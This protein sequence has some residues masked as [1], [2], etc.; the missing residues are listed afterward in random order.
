MGKDYTKQ[1]IVP[2]CYLA[3]FG[4]NGNEGRRSKVYYY[5]KDRC[6][7]GCGS[8]EKFPVENG[9]YDIPE[10]G[11]KE[12][13]LEFF[14][15]KIETQLSDLLKNLLNFVV[16]EKVDRSGD[17]VYYE[18]S[19]RAELCG[20]FALLIQRTDMQRKQI[21]SIYEQLC[22]GFPFIPVPAYDKEDF[23]RLH[24]NQILDLNQANFY[25]NMFENTK[26]AVLVNHT[27]LPFWTSDN[28]IISINHGTQ[29]HI[30]ATSDH[31]TYYIPISPKFSIEMYPKSVNWNDLAYFDLYD[32]RIIANYNKYI[33]KECTRMV[34]SNKEF[35]F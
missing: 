25:A 18:P 6:V 22:E 24:N 19:M 7:S 14:F 33:E 10:L 31:L 20:Q 12:K 13:A 4:K 21:Q 23:K 9:F 15:Q 30:S 28:P 34:F 32:E 29:E 35:R 2:A 26:W 11:E 16:Y 17:R 5:I 8:V 3:N 1:H 27:D